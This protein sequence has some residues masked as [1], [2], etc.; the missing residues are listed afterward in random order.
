MRDALKITL[1]TANPLVLSQFAFAANT[2]VTQFFLARHST[3]A[4]H[5]SLPG[6]L[7]GVTFMSFFNATLGYAGTVFAQHDG[8]GHR[9]RAYSAFI[10]SL[11]LTLFSLPLLALGCPLARLILGIFNASPAV[12]AA[13]ARY[14]DILM[15]NAALTIL[16][17]V[18]GGFFMGQGKTRFVGATTTLGFIT[19]IALAPIFIAGYLGPGGLLGAGIAQ[20]LAHLVPVILLGAALW[21]TPSLHERSVSWK[22]SFSARETLEILEL[23]IPNGLRTVLEIGGFFAFTALIAEL[24]TASAAASTIVFALN[25]VGY[26]AVQG[27]SSALEIL[28]G[29]SIGARKVNEAR[30]FLVVSIGLTLLLASVYAGTLFAFG[31]GLVRLFSTDAAILAA[32]TPLLLI[33]A[34]KAPLEF[35]VL[36]LQGAL[37]GCG[38]T[39]AV[40]RSLLIASCLVWIPAYILVRVFQPN[41]VLY[42]LTMV[43]SCLANLLGLSHALRKGLHPLLKQD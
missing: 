4:L 19:N 12:Y 27:L 22:P 6:S 43:I 21:R 10:Q 15:P 14:F 35:L 9:S 33:A 38:K 37:R 7:L 3:T 32:S 20:T 23:G 29:R 42:W 5:A 26:S 34:L 24:D 13:E 36:T 28:T 2:F 8:A 18:L 39:A 11:W 41:I 30:H 31:K 25:G 16:G 17:S 1:R 40:F